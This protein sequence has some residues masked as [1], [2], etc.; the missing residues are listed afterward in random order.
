MVLCV[1]MESRLYQS[2]V[3]TI[4]QFHLM[5]ALILVVQSILA[6]TVQE[7]LQFVKKFVGIR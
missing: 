2:N 5:G 6:L 4:I 3:M 1:G 7:I